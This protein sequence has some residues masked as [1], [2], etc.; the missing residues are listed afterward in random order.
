MPPLLSTLF[1]EGSC[2][3]QR[4]SEI[5]HLTLWVVKLL[6]IAGE[7]SGAVRWKKKPSA[8]SGVENKT[9]LCLEEILN[10]SLNK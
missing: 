10:T 2:F 9:E 5:N 4:S 6:A 7:D 3:N 1:S 8:V